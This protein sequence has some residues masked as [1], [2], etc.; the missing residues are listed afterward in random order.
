MFN[1]EIVEEMTFNTCHPDQEKDALTKALAS[2]L[3][4]LVSSCFTTEFPPELGYWVLITAA[5]Q[6]LGRICIGGEGLHG[7]GCCHRR[8]QL[9][10]FSSCFWRAKLPI[11]ISQSNVM[12]DMSQQGHQCKRPDPGVLHIV[13]QRI[14]THSHLIIIKAP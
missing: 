3:L 6:G 1:L 9:S 2:Q 11:V 7:E 8:A 5:C 4:A 12:Q 14:R 10:V 13:R